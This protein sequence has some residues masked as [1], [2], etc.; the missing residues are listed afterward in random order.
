MP[1]FNQKQVFILIGGGLLAILAI[2]LV[3]TNLRSSSKPPEL[4][5]N[6]WGTESRGTV[7]GVLGSYQQ[8][9]PNVRINYTQVEPGR[10]DRTLLDALAAGE[11]PDVFMI[12]N[13]SL[14]RDINK[15]SPADPSQ[16][17][18][19]QFRDDFPTVAEQDFVSGGKIYALPLFVDTL[20]L[21]YNRDLFDRASIVAPPQTWEDFQRLAPYLR[22]LDPN[23]QLSQAAAAIG[24]TDK[25]VPHSADLLSV[26][27]L[28]NGTRMN[29][30]RGQSVFAA[31]EGQQAFNF[32]LQFANPSSDYYTWNDNQT[33]AF[34]ALKNGKLAM[35][36]GYYSDL[37]SIRSQSPFLRV[38]AA[39]LP[40][41]SSNAISYADYW[42]LA[43]S[44][45]SKWPAWGWDLALFL[46]TNSDMAKMYMTAANRPPALRALIGQYVNDSNLGVFARQALT[47]RSW[48]E[49]DAAQ[50]E[51]IL[52]SA[53]QNVL[54]GKLNSAQALRQAQ[55]QINQLIRQ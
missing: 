17:S 14:S 3:F 48:I 39:P 23:G 12:H 42:G 7:D 32:Y 55:D 8:M 26:L 49:P 54:L 13:R 27:M 53:I 34:T 25:T 2:Y 21:L 45:Q 18:L 35:A 51:S 20:A 11:G 19:S 28:Q 31:G 37:L 47:A 46:T 24:G 43:V 4:T 10:Y 5:L 15:L 50:T 16:L 22:K 9:R 30:E 29:D 41:T 6:V 52:N 1:Q 40:Q 44:K 38:A 36:F 33:P